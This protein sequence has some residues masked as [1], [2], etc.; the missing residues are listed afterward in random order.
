MKY[1]P[2]I[3]RMLALH[4]RPTSA[5]ILGRV[6]AT[7]LAVSPFVTC[8]GGPTPPGQPVEVPEDR[9]VSWSPDGQWLAFMHTAPD[10]GSSDISVAR[11]DGSGRRVVVA[12]GGNPAW[13]P[14]GNSLLYDVGIGGKVHLVDLAADS[15]RVLP[16]MG[17]D[18]TATMSPDGR[19]VAFSSDGND[20]RNP[21]DLWLMN[22]AGTEP[23]RIWLGPSPRNGLSE[24]TWAPSG[25]RLAASGALSTSA[26]SYVE[27]IFVTDTAGRDT[28]WITPPSSNARNPA[29]SPLGDWI[30][31]TRL[32]GSGE[33]RLVRPDGTEDHLLETDAYEPAWSPDGQRVAFSRRTAQEV[34]IWSVDISG[35]ALQRLSWPQ[36]RPAP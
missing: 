27:A 3:A 35:D 14:D 18:G 7:C 9:N 12:F 4:G 16:G 24:P 17:W 13:T 2:V 8:R 10:S 5:R 15:V 36:G 28:A 20:S 30:A 32:V 1:R 23:R 22:A 19:T 26:A 6:A 29:W 25:D 33:I 34:A 21:P 31:Y 11:L